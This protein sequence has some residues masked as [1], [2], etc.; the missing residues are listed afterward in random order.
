MSPLLATRCHL[1]CPRDVCH[2]RLCSI[3]EGHNP[4]EVNSIMKL[5][6]I[7][8]VKQPSGS[9]Q[10][11]VMYLSGI[12]QTL[13]STNG[14]CL[15]QRLHCTD[16]GCNPDEVNSIVGFQRVIQW[17]SKF[18]TVVRQSSGSYQS[19]HRTNTQPSILQI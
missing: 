9:C 10:V 4:N 19:C 15:V 2:P 1:L 7:S 13:F 18:V 17:L 3:E 12:H 11:A 16:E 5:Q 8:V 6:A 14:T